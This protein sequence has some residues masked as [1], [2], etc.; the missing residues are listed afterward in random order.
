MTHF[1]IVLVFLVLGAFVIALLAISA[2]FLDDVD[3]CLGCF[4]NAFVVKQLLRP[5][6]SI[7][8]GWR[9]LGLRA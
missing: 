7:R 6:R 4:H 5:F 2:H 8:F 3:G 1:T 9:I